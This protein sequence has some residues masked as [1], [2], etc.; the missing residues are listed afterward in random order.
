MSELKLSKILE[1]PIS[2]EQW[3]D[4]EHIM[5]FCLH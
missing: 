3:P 5:Y 2:P 1:R 4:L